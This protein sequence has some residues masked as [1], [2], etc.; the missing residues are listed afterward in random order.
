MELVP[1]GQDGEVYIYRYINGKKQYLTWNG[2]KVTVEINS[3]SWTIGKASNP[4]YYVWVKYV[5]LCDISHFK[6]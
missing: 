3:Y 2:Y 1:S 5:I 4:V 6:I